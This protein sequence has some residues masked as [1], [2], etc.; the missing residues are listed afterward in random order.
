[1]PLQPTRSRVL[2]GITADAIGWAGGAQYGQIGWRLDPRA[3]SH[4]GMPS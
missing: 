1:M 4:V 2:V 3:G